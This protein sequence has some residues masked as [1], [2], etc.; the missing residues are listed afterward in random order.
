[1]DSSRFHGK[2]LGRESEVRHSIRDESEIESPH[3][4]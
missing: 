2:H 3:H 1:M 4:A